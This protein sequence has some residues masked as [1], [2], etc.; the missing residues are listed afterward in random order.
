MSYFRW[1]ELCWTNSW[2]YLDALFL[3]V[4]V[5]LNKSVDLFRRVI[6]GCLDCVEK[7]RG[8]IRMPY[9]GLFWLC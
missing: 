6:F 5:V 8:S 2:I 3:A 1:F 7:I 9:F 4:W